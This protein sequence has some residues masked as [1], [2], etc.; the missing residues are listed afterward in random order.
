MALPVLETPTYE[1][2]LP[3]TNQKVSYRPFLVKEH[4]V[5]MTLSKSSNN[6][7]YRTVND[8]IDSCTFGKIDKEKLTSFD[9][10]YIFLNI[11]SKSI[12]EKIKLKLICTKCKDELPTVI[13]LNEVE[14]EKEEISHDIKLRNNTVMKLRFPKFYEKMNIVEGS[15]DDIIERVADCIVNVKTDDNFYDDF[16]K[17]D[18]NNFLLQLTTD[19]FTQ[20][21]DFFGKMPKVVLKTQAECK[22]C[23]IISKTKL[24][25]LHDFFL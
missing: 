18:A 2:N 13:N 7:I 15:E 25:G 1:I 20:I 19:E 17:E 11:R 5:L 23:N 4:K 8:L 12:G 22:K 3:S 6:E 14:I 10:E 16:T 24:Q 9:T 21:E